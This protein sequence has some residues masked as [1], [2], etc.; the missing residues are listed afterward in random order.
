[1]LTMRTESEEAR[2]LRVALEEMRETQAM[3]LE[4]ADYLD[5]LPAV[6]T[7]RALA[8]RLRARLP[9]PKQV[10]EKKSVDLHGR[11]PYIPSGLPLLEASLIANEL[12]IWIPTAI[13]GASR[14]HVLK[15]IVKR[16][17]EGH[18]GLA[19]FEPAGEVEVAPRSRPTTA[20]S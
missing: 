19:L 11:G 2:Q 18:L 3:L 20:R 8:K 17:S 9:S 5:R 15:E 7:T 10:V 13:K 16:L 1:M 14:D 12:R 6:P 4:T